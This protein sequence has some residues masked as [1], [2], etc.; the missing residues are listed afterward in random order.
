VAGAAAN[1]PLDFFPR[2]LF[3]GASTTGRALMSL[4]NDA[5]LM[6]LLT[7]HKPAL[8]ARTEGTRRVRVGRAAAW[9]QTSHLRKVIVVALASEAARHKFSAAHLA[10]LTAQAEGLETRCAVFY[11]ADLALEQVEKGP[12]FD[13]LA[14]G[15]READALLFRWAFANLVD[16]PTAGPLLERIRLGRGYR[17]DAEDV[18][19]LVALLQQHWEAVKATVPFTAERLAELASELAVAKQSEPATGPASAAERRGN[20]PDSLPFSAADAS[21]S[22]Y[23]HRRANCSTK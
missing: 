19:A 2:P 23:E 5:D 22:Q 6:N 1:V 16:H 13:E 14:R 17:D 18:I 8:L 3:H 15:V 4:P 11:A 12:A 9:E 7:E 10:E 21:R 20:P